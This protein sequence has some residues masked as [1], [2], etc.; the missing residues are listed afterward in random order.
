[1]LSAPDDRGSLSPGYGDNVSDATPPTVVTATALPGGSMDW[2]KP[3]NAEYGFMVTAI[4]A[5]AR[6]EPVPVS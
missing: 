2:T 3:A 5:G 1:M 4:D 6:V